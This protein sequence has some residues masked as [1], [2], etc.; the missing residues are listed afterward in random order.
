MVRYFICLLISL[1]AL[2]ANAQ[3]F[4]ATINTGNP[5]P[6]VNAGFCKC[7]S[8]AHDGIDCAMVIAWRDDSSKVALAGFGFID[9]NRFQVNQIPTPGMVAKPGWHSWNQWTCKCVG[10]IGDRDCVMIA[11][12]IPSIHEPWVMYW[13]DGACVIPNEEVMTLDPID[14][15]CNPATLSSCI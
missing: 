10:D 4:A 8:L 15:S 12:Y 5:E 9:M 1:F 6:Q 13:M 11:T 14:W 3:A 7:V 2:S